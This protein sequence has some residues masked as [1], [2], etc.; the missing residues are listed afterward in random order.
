MIEL[1]CN[2]VWRSKGARL[3]AGLLAASLLAVGAQA[4]EL[5]DAPGKTDLPNVADRY[6]GTGVQMG[7]FWLLPTIETGLFYD[8]NIN[9]SSSNEQSGAG[10]YAIPRVEL[11]SDWG[12]HALNFVVEASDYTYFDDS[13]Q[14]RFNIDGSMDT[15]IDIRRD[16]IFA[17]GAKGGRFQEQVGDLN[18]NYYADEPTTYWDFNTWASLMKAFNRIQISAGAAYDYQ[19]YDDVQ[20]IF[21]TSIDQDYRNGHVLEAGG[22]VAYAISPGYSV[23]SDFRYNWRD[24]ND[25]LSDSDGWRALTGLEFEIGRLLNGEIGVGYMNQHY[26]EGQGN[27]GGFTYHAGL[28][29]NPTPLMTVTLD[30][31]RE[32]QDSAQFDSPG[33]IADDVELALNYEVRRGWVLTPSLVYQRVDYMDDDGVESSYGLGI[34][35]DYTMNRFWTLGAGYSYT[36]ND[37]QDAPPL[38]D[39]WDRHVVG[40]YAKARF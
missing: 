33:S 1:A 29:W 24:Y 4:Q 15:R 14:N 2:M 23:F 16:L 27:E 40:A 22:R 11:N 37:Y 31:N 7:S 9:A 25:K 32:V 18:T 10:V 35:L 20:S 26:G 30:A 34:K 5:E 19:N 8:S 38:V 12:R 36:Y 28:T 17:G 39:N 3:A 13:S 6:D 21:G